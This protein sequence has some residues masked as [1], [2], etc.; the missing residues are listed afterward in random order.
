MYKKHH[1]EGEI[2]V[3]RPLNPKEKSRLPPLGLLFCTSFLSC[4]GRAVERISISAGTD[5]NE[6]TR[7]LGKAG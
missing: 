1:S 4:I 2:A 7:S 3:I 5:P 6:K